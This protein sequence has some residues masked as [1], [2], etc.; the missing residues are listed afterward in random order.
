VGIFMGGGAVEVL[1]HR[2]CFG[3]DDGDGDVVSGECADDFG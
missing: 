2:L 1:Q 3:L